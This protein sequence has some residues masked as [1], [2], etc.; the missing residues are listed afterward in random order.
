MALAD[1]NGWLGWVREARNPC[2]YSALRS[3]AIPKW[4]TCLGCGCTSE[5]MPV[6]PHSEEYGSTEGQYIKSCLPL[7][8][9]CHAVVHLRYKYPQVFV[10]YKRNVGAKNE[11][12]VFNTLNAAFQ[13]IFRANQAYQGDPRLL[14]D[15]KSGTWL[16]S[17]D[18]V[19]YSGP[20]KV[21][22]VVNSEGQHVPDPKVYLKPWTSF[23]AVLVADTVKHV[24]FKRDTLN[25]ILCED[26]R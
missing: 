1:Y 22:T 24:V 7:C 10:R 4:D 19:P 21:A 6:A 8:C 17:L 13:N 12:P 15:F 18:I 25:R 20:A 11:L 26:L 9:R 5:T 16:D 3:G 2:Y 23:E 14:Q